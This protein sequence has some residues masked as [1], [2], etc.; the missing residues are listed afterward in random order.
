MVSYLYSAW[1]EDLNASADDQDREWIA[2]IVIEADTSTAAK[3][4]GDT[5]AIERSARAGYDTFLRSEVEV[6]STAKGVMD[7]SNLPR[8]A[9][10]ERVSDK[11]IGW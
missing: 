8:I 10:G 3:Q 2:C 1:F 11:V 6:A 5:L 7:W 9:A 4:W